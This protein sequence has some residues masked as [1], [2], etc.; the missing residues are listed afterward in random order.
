LDVTSASG[1]NINLWSLASLSPDVDGDALNF[2]NLSSYSWTLAQTTDGVI[3]FDP[4]NFNIVTDPNNG[5]AGFSNPLDGGTFSLAVSDNA[6]SLQF[7]PIP[8]PS[9]LIIWSLLGAFGIS[10]GW[11]RRRRRQ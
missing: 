10:V 6:L 4:A 1:Y 7:N 8:E 9:T 2:D 3:G 5:T 11:W